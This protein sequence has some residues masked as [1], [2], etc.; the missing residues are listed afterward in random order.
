ML[1]NIITNVNNAGL[2]E[3]NTA[4][5]LI[6]YKGHRKE[7]TSDRSYRTISSCPF[8]AKSLD[9]YLR[10]LYS[11]RWEDKQADTQYQGTGSSHD[12]AALL[13]TEAIQH[14]LFA[15]NQP[16][17][18][19]A[20]DAESAFDRCLR[21]VLVSELY[22]AH[23]QTAAILVIDTRLASRITVYEWEGQVMGPAVD[24]TGFEQG[25]INSSD[26]YKLC[27]NEQLK[28]AQDSMLGVDIGS[29]VIS[30]IGQADDVI[31]ISSSIHSLQMLV[32]LTEQ[33]CSKFRVK[34]EPSKTKLLAYCQDKQSFVVDHALNSQQ[35]MINNKPV[36]LATEVEHVGI[37]RNVTGNVPHIV[38]RVAM[39]KNS[40]HALLPAGTG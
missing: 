28:T 34:L 23:L 10:D 5:G 6:F 38:N 33:Y 2:T 9:L 16:V 29:Q 31:L 19:L 37:L 18:M 36:K 13:V 39:H 17:Y 25:G 14:S 1:N 24:A 7:K 20:L 26:F 15:N 40:L 35:I 21:Q 8:L 22:K 12:L 30:A 11:D 4:H 3:L 32:S 27:N